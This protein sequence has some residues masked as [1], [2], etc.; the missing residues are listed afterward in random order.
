MELIP[1]DLRAKLLANGALPGDIED[2]DPFPVV[3][4]FT[5][6]GWA[7]WL[8]TEL[9]P[10]DPDLAY[11]LCD[12]GLGA[13]KLGHVRLSDLAEIAGDDLACDLGFAARQSLSAYLHE[14]KVAGTI[15]P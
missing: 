3:R 15:V 12:L 9:N 8:L 5:P 14:A 2:R 11:G 1:A 4:L 6:G 13:P 7:S 10:D